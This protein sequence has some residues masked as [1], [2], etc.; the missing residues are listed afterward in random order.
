MTGFPLAIFEFPILGPLMGS[1]GEDLAVRTF[2]A[3]MGWLKTGNFRATPNDHWESLG[4]CL[5][6]IGWTKGGH[7]KPWGAYW[8]ISC[9]FSQASAGNNPLNGIQCHWGLT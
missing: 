4:R 9:R 7:I 8:S 1:T 2:Q 5:V 6:V 3:G